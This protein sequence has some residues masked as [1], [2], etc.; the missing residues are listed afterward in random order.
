ME[1]LIS[2]AA[3]YWLMSIALEIVQ[4]RLERHFGRGAEPVGRAEAGV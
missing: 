3:I 4:S 2:A 1:M